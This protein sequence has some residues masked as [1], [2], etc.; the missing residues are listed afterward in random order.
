MPDPSTHDLNAELRDLIAQRAVRRGRFQLASGRE[1]SF[2]I[3]AKQ[4]VLDAHGAMLVGRVILERLRAQGTLPAAVGG[5]S[6]GE[7]ASGRDAVL[8]G[9][10]GSR[11][12]AAAW[13]AGSTVR[14][15]TSCC[16]RTV[17]CATRR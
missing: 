10:R 2:Y 12:T 15:A 9:L 1:A 4:V 7:I 17:P 5:M 8:E 3:D 11:G 16:R 14:T 13:G 6:I